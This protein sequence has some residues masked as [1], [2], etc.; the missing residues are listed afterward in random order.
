MYWTFHVF[1]MWKKRRSQIFGK[2]KFIVN[3]IHQATN[4]IQ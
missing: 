3:L 1:G 2:Q 4:H